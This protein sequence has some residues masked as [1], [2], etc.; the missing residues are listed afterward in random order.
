MT[1]TPTE[2]TTP[3]NFMR[4]GEGPIAPVTDEAFRQVWEPRGYSAVSD[5]DAEAAAN[6]PDQPKTEAAAAEA[7]APPA[8]SPAAPGRPGG[9]TPGG[10]PGGQPPTP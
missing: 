1:T 6:A 2:S 8:A 3:V 5:A 10:T 4:L 9:G 7:P